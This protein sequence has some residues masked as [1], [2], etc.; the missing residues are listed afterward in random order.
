MLKCELVDKWFRGGMRGVA[1]EDQ[2]G[3]K[4]CG[5]ALPVV[6]TSHSM[7]CIDSHMKLS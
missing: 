5:N 1:G 4:I 7:L 6:S 2:A 3:Q